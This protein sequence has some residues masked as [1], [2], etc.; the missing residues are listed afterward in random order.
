MK[1]QQTEYR[2]I[3]KKKV[4]RPEIVLSKGEM[5]EKKCKNFLKKKPPHFHKKEKVDR[6]RSK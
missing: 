5:I 4:Y 2:E 6:T 3:Y 1:R